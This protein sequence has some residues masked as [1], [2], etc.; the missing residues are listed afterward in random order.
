MTE[1]SLGRDLNP[2]D[3]REHDPDCELHE[4]RIWQHYDAQE[5]VPACRCDDLARDRYDDEQERRADVANEHYG[6]M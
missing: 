3:E 5:G 4:D 6:G 2:P 1:T